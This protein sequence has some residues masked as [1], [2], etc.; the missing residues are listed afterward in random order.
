[1]TSRRTPAHI[2]RNVGVTLAILAS[3]GT[4]AVASF[5]GA[6]T[7]PSGGTVTAL[8]MP[9]PVAPTPQWAPEWTSSTVGSPQAS[10]SG[11]GSISCP[12]SGDCIAAAANGTLNGTITNPGESFYT[13]TDANSTTPTW[14]THSTNFVS[15][16][17]LYQY[18]TQKAVCSGVSFCMVLVNGLTS[19]TLPV[20]FGSSNTLYQEDAYWWSNDPFGP[21]PSWNF[22]VY[23]VN[24]Q[25]QTNVGGQLNSYSADFPYGSGVSAACAGA[26][27]TI[28][29]VITTDQGWTF[30]Q[31]FSSVTGPGPTGV[32]L[33]NLASGWSGARTDSNGGTCGIAVLPGGSVPGVWPAW[34]SSTYGSTSCTGPISGRPSCYM[35]TDSTYPQGFAWCLTPWANG[36]VHWGTLAWYGSGSTGSQ[37]LGCSTCTA[38]N[39]T[40]IPGTA[41][42][43]YPDLIA[44]CADPYWCYLAGSGFFAVSTGYTGSGTSAY[45]G[46]TTFSA[47]LSQETN[48]PGSF[49]QVSG[50]CPPVGSPFPCVI[51]TA[52]QCGDDGGT[53][54]VVGSSPPEQYNWCVG[55]D[56][57]GGVYVTDNAGAGSLVGGTSGISFGMEGPV[58][59]PNSQYPDWCQGPITP[60]AAGYHTSVA[61]E[62]TAMGV[63]AP[64]SFELSCPWSV[65]SEKGAM[66]TLGSPPFVDCYSA[67]EWTTPQSNVTPFVTSTQ[68]ALQVELTGVAQTPV[69]DFSGN[70][71]IGQG[72]G[73]QNLLLRVPG[74]YPADLPSFPD[75]SG[76]WMI[77]LPYS[78]TSGVQAPD[79]CV[80][81]GVTN[82][83][84]N[85]NRSVGAA[86][87]WSATTSPPNPLWL[88]LTAESNGGPSTGHC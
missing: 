5:T 20:I 57:Y 65:Q 59:C 36:Y 13:S 21:S 15:G 47:D 50:G 45:I 74:Q 37:Y 14:T 79:S 28:G 77:P 16:G 72:V 22:D 52:L 10:T 18:M 31:W 75:G 61:N 70:T 76:A 25:T 7:P 38:A 63:V 3:G 71:V 53:A 42:T 48:D 58:S 86:N 46:T 41:S 62:S 55:V 1:M 12:L 35:S 56:F 51:T 64:I 83:S 29:C 69:N 49:N 82:T 40:E 27:T 85:L 68:N 9:T 2:L 17:T 34:N 60:G 81:F 39:G 54:G 26:S 6:A 11:L 43:Q 73:T 33:A 84:G 66:A 8:A 80:F 78:G 67:N 24:N 23:A 32:S 44:S 87:Y 88:Y 30:T 19:S 4:A